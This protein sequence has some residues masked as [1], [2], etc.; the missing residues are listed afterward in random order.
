MENKIKKEMQRQ[1]LADY[2]EQMATAL[3]K[4]NFETGR[5]SE[6]FHEKAK[7]RV[8]FTDNLFYILRA[9]TVTLPFALLL[10]ACLRPGAC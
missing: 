8:Q 9:L 7:S 4:G 10:R 3:R 6:P 5:Y 2:L 1:E